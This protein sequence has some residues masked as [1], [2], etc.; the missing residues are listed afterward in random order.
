M[1]DYTQAIVNYIKGGKPMDEYEYP[2]FKVL[3]KQIHPHTG[4]GAL[5]VEADNLAAVQKHTYRWTKSL[6]VTASIMPGL[7]DEE[8]VEL[9]ASMTS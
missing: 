6:G 2:G 1:R 4:G 7:S 5:M 3:A 9:E 8:Y